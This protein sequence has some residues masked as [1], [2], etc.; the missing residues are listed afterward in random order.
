MI[1]IDG[2][3][4]E[5]DEEMKP[6]WM[7]EGEFYSKA[8]HNFYRDM[9]ITL[10]AFALKVGVRSL[11]VNNANLQNTLNIGTDTFVVLSAFKLISG[12][13]NYFMS[14]DYLSK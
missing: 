11:P 10:G 2:T 1:N 12:L 6:A 3:A 4:T 9:A 8:R 13:F 5:V 14:A 7:N